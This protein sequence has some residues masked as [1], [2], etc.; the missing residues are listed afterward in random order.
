MGIFSRF[1]DIVNSNINALLDSAEDPNKMIRLIIQEMEETLVEV[2]SSCARIIADKKEVQRRL[3]RYQG[4]VQ[5][6]EAKAKLAISKGRD[7]LA[8]AAIA[9]KTEIEAAQA[10]AEA[11]LFGYDDHLDTLSDEVA[12]LQVKL[13]DAKSQQ[14]ALLLRAKSAENR[15]KVKKQLHKYNQEDAFEKFESF[16]RKMDDLEGQVESFDVGR[17]DLASE[18]DQLKKDDSI[19]TELDRLKAELLNSDSKT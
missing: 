2:R 11:E 15:Y 8:R 1:A 17:S 4:D 14:K 13:N 6:W 10:E 16:Q 12:Q 18:I 19:N 9:Q 7:D 5:E 3:T